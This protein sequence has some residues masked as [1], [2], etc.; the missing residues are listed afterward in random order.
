[1]SHELN[2]VGLN[3]TDDVRQ[4]I[5]DAAHARRVTVAELFRQ[6]LRSIGVPVPEV[7]RQGR[8][9]REYPAAALAALSAAPAPAVAPVP[10]NDNTVVRSRVRSAQPAPAPA[11]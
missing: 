10:R 4:M 9:K 1:M 8:P 7:R 2:T 6:G 3:V 11:A 5:C